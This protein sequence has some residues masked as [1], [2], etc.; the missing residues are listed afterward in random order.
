MLLGPLGG[1]VA[2]AFAAGAAAGWGFC[3]ATILRVTNKQIA[4]LEKELEQERA[5]CARE[6]AELKQRLQIVEDRYTTG[7]E[8]QLGQIRRSS[9]RILGD[10]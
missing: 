2:L 3:V 7:M 1:V 8:R 6:I 5:D 10:E 4:R 9:R